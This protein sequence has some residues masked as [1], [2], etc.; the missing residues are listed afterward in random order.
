MSTNNP[1]VSM[2][3]YADLLGGSIAPGAASEGEVDLLNK[4]MTAGT[5]R[6]GNFGSSTAG[7][8]SALRMESLEDTLK[9]ITYRE[10]MIKFWRRIKKKAAFNTVEEWNILKEYGGDGGVFTGEGELGETVDSTYER[11]T[12]T[13]K[14]MCI[15][16]E[17]SHP[18]M[19]VRAAHGSV[20]ATETANK[21]KHLLRAVETKLFDG[22][23]DCVSVEFDGMFYQILAD[24][25]ITVPHTQLYSAT[26]VLGGDAFTGTVVIDKRNSPIDEDDLELAANY[27]L[28]NYAELNTLWMAPRANSDIGKALYPRQRVDLPMPQNGMAGLALN[29]FKSSAGPI[30]FETDI[31]MRSGHKH[32]VKTAPTAATS[33]K[34]PTAPTFTATAAA[35]GTKSMF[36]TADAGAYYWSV[37]AVN[38]YG[39]SVAATAQTAS[40]SATQKVTLAITDGGGTYPA[41]AYRIYRSEVGGGSTGARKL[42]CIIP[43][44]P[45]G[46]TSFVDY[47]WFIPG[48]SSAWMTQ[49]DDIEHHSFRQLAPM[50][51]M[52]LATVGP[53]LRWMQLMYG[54]PLLYKPRQNVVFINVK[55][56]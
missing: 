37:T 20:V 40:P 31:F 23:S 6:G 15:V 11:K 53:S 25:G 44:T 26:D 47:N 27:G 50:M 36:K 9:I 21:T 34:A 19:L 48:T 38:R 41:T 22:R 54:M 3:D 13:V 33:T 42:M 28:Q 43:V 55:D 4:A 51:R 29:G 46:S 39:E 56:D 10:N 7:D 52:P 18:M 1:M 16:G 45:G 35:D 12:G 24:R 14:F 8:G 30:A 32:G 17:V 49:E 2:N 5:A